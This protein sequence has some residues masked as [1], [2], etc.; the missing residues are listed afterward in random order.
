LLLSVYMLAGECLSIILSIRTSPIFVP[1]S[2]KRIVLHCR[3][4]RVCNKE[5]QIERETER[6]ER[7]RSLAAAWPKLKLAL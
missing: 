1:A 6:E 2:P 4:G 3:A 7:E 5:K